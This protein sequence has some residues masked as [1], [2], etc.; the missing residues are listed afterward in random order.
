MRKIWAAW[1]VVMA[2]CHS[3]PTGWFA[4]TLDGTGVPTTLVPVGS[5]DTNTGGE[6]AHQGLASSLM[7]NGNL[8]VTGL[9]LTRMALGNEVIDTQTAFAAEVEPATGHVLWVTRDPLP[10]D[11]SFSSGIFAAADPSGKTFLGYP[12]AG[13]TVVELEPGGQIGWRGTH[14]TNGDLLGMVSD[15]AGGVIVLAGS[16]DHFDLTAIDINPG[17]PRWTLPVVTDGVES[18]AFLTPSL[19]ADGQGGAVIAADASANAYFVMRVDAKGQVAWKNLIA[20]GAL[21][22]TSGA[23]HAGPIAVDLASQTIRTVGGPSSSGFAAKLDLSGKFLGVLGGAPILDSAGGLYNLDFM[24]ET[25]DAAVRHLDETHS[26]IWSVALPGWIDASGE[27]TAVHVTSDGKTLL[28]GQ[29][30]D[31]LTVG[32][33]QLP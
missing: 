29:R 21:R 26:S 16:V 4:A 30:S 10:E 32:T 18:P 2:G 12:L 14:S 15:G 27:L 24:G 20:P 28:F 8:V 31:L 7:P 3:H 1:I 22:I 5:Y 6:F 17:G 9:N 23:V 11:F 25:P 19:A 33:L 13:V